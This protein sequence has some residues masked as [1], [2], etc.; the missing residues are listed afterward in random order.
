MGKIKLLSYQAEILEKTDHFN[1][2]AYYLDMGLG[3]TFV[4]SEKAISYDEQILL[5]CQKSKIQ[6]W[7]DHFND[8]YPDEIVADLSKKNPDYTAGIMVIN[9]DIVWRREEIGKLKKITLMLDESS[10][11]KNPKSKRTK[12]TMNIDYQN[13]IL[14]SGTPTGGKYEEL[15]TQCNMLGWRISQHAFWK[16]YVKYYE[17]DT[18]GFK[19][20]IPTGYKNVRE[21]KNRLKDFGA[22]FM[23]T[24]EVIDL[25]DQIEQIIH[26]KQ[27][28]EYKR[29]FEDR[30]VT[31]DGE[32]L[33]GDMAMTQMM[34][35][36]QLAGLYS[37]PKMAALSDL[38]ESTED[39]LIL[40]YN[41]RAEFDNIKKLCKK[42]NKPLSYVNGDGR[43]LKNYDFASNSVTLVQY[44]SGAMGLNLQKSNKI[45]YYSL[46][47]SGELFE[48]SK[49][50]THRVGQ[51]RTC[52]Y[53][54]LMT[55]ESIEYHIKETL[56]KRED[57]NAK[58]FEKVRR[59]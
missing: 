38:M 4:G 6:D 51:S 50:R 1:K 32:E 5:V 30:L 14:L 58:L 49:K 36:R 16:Q 19:I 43:D 15:I 46:P 18:G 42:L 39:R 27:I 37:K 52:F 26:V 47:L 3:K 21:L 28:P 7:V 20:K 56:A 34:Y 48:Q 55:E 29:M 53:Y 24:D 13:L 22:V 23:K 35:L 11:V 9:Y 44:Q 54:Y 2:V 10:C 33:V 40:F 59:R 45:I 57:Y 41:F 8:F 31:I 25:P 17:I 12:A